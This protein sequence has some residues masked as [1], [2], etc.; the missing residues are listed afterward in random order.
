MFKLLNKDAAKAYHASA[1]KSPSKKS[2]FAETVATRYPAIYFENHY[3][4]IG[5]DPGY[6][7]AVLSRVE[8][9]RR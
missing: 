4:T 3:Y 6:G 5:R 2:A 7:S 1:L 8:P 9:R